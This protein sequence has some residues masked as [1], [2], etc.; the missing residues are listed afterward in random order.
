MICSAIP[1]D[2]FGMSY[3]LDSPEGRLQ[4][5][6]EKKYDDAADFARAVG[7][8]P[9]TYR[10]YEAGRNGFAKHVALFAKKLGVDPSWLA[11]GLGT[12]TGSQPEGLAPAISARLLG[13]LLY[14]LGPSLPKG[15]LSESAAEALAGALIHGIELLP[16]SGAN[17][18]SEDALGVAARAAVLRFREAL[19]S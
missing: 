10:A 8:K 14:T 12:P 15:D 13:R 18:A 4:W 6:R 7:L 3:D 5:A 17:D 9:V 11:H 1:C 16:G 19:N 2:M